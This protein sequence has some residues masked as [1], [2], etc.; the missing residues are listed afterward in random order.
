M[1]DSRLDVQVINWG[2]GR[3]EIDRNTNYGSRIVFDHCINHP[4]SVD[5]AVNKLKAFEVFLRNELPTPRWTPSRNIALSWLDR[6]FSVVVRS[7][8]CG[9]SGQGIELIKDNT[10]EL[11]F[12][13]LYTRYINKQAEYRV[14]VYNGQVIDFQ[15]KRRRQAHHNPNWQIRSHINGWNY[16]RTFNP[17]LTSDETNRI[18]LAG[19]AAVRTLGLTFGAVDIVTSGSNSPYILEVNTAPGLEGRTLLAYLKAITEKYRAGYATST[20]ETPYFQELNARITNMEASLNDL[21]PLDVPTDA[22]S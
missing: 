3:Q 12:A 2:L 13:P 18:K 20:Q 11:P 14:H 15:Q 7:R 19:I 16:T 6:G 5:L 8:L 9:H 4:N 21:Q 17:I 1:C 10:E 22:T